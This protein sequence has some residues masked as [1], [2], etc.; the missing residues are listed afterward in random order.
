MLTHLHGGPREPVYDHTRA[1][2]SVHAAAPGA[3]APQAAAEQVLQQRVAHDRVRYHL[4]GVDEFPGV[5]VAGLGW[6]R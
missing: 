5:R 6:Q 3:A 4:A 2:P 1:L